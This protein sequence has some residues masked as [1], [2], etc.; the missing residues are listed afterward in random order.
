MSRVEQIECVIVDVVGRLSERHERIWPW[1]VGAQLDF[2][3]CEQTL[4]RDMSRM[5]RTGKLARIGI[6]KGYWPVGRLQ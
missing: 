4:R 2:Y 1:M 3:R 5:A 6:R